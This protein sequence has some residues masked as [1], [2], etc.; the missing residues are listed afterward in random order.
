MNVSIDSASGFGWGVSIV[1][2]FALAAVSCSDADHQEQARARAEAA[3]EVRARI[4]AMDLA[5]LSDAMTQRL[6]A[7][8]TYAERGLRLEEAHA[9]GREIQL[10]FTLVHTSEG[11]LDQVKQSLARQA[12]LDVGCVQKFSGAFFGAEGFMT[13]QFDY[14]DGASAFVETIRPGDCAAAGRAEPELS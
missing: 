2:L 14:A 9:N 12:V 8:W 11:A 5:E 13:V 6:A 7:A 1:G 4:E 3:E 10:R